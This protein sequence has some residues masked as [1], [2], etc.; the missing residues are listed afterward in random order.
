MPQ[1][2]I[3]RA[4]IVIGDWGIFGEPTQ[5]VRM[6]DAL[7]GISA[8]TRDGEVIQAFGSVTR[9][10]RATTLDVAVSRGRSGNITYQTR[11][12]FRGRLSHAFGQA[13]VGSSSRLE[14]VRI[15]LNAALNLQQFLMAQPMP[16]RHPRNRAVQVR[17]FVTAISEKYAQFGQE[18]C[19]T[20][21]TNLLVGP[22]VLYR[23]ALSKQAEAH[24]SDYVAV[25]Q[26]FLGN[27]FRDLAQDYGVRIVPFPYYS[28][29][30]VEFLWEFHHS[31]PVRLVEALERPMR[32]L[33][34]KKRRHRA[35]VRGEEVGTHQDSFSVQAE[36][37]SGCVLVA[38]AKT[39]KRV[40]FELRL[41]KYCIGKTLSSGRTTNRISELERMMA[42]LRAWATDQFQQSLEGLE[43]V[44]L[45]PSS[46]KTSIDLCTKVSDVLS[47]TVLACTVLETLRC[48]GSLASPQQ[49]PMKHAAERLR[50]AGILQRRRSRSPTYVPTDAWVSAVRELR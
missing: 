36:L 32:T 40:R 38:Y 10:S 22:S 25:V 31:H 23:Y 49:S 43:R 11:P 50:E 17:E 21:E 26:N 1:A 8:M 28:L 29:R 30:H 27:E 44:R 16:R 39:N 5:I 24:F 12:V 14:H 33:G 7:P 42:N 2:M 35:L 48:R 13:R 41:D 37:S 45:P 9:N 34:P 3:D 6:L 46:R 15:G 20:D 18:Y 47:D 4:E 19:L